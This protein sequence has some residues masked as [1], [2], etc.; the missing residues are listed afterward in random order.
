MATVKF[1]LH[2]TTNEEV[3]IYTYLSLGKNNLIET[4]TGF[5]IN[6]KNW[7]CT[8]ERKDKNDKTIKPKK[9]VGLP[10][11]NIAETKKLHNNIIDLQSYIFKNLN[12]SLSNGDMI[13]KY[14]LDNQIKECFNRKEKT[15]NTLL[16]SHIQYII[17]NA[18]TRKIQGTNRIGL[19]KA[20]VT[21]YKTF[22]K[23]IIQYQEHINKNIHFIDI[24]KPLV[25]KF[26]NWLMSKQEV[27]VIKKD[28]S[29][30]KT[31]REPY[32]VGYSGKQIS[33]LKGVCN[34]A[35]SN[36]IEVNP[37]CSQIETFKESKEDRYIQILTFDELE[38]IR[39][40]PVKDALNNVKK[41]LL[42][43]CDIGQRGED[44]V[45]LTKDNIRYIQNDLVLDI[46]QDKGKKTVTAPILQDYV[47]E[48]IENDFPYKISTQKLNIHVKKLCKL[49]GLTEV[50]KGY[51]DINERKVLGT[52][53][54]YELIA[55][56][57]FRRSFCSN[58]YK[59]VPT[60]VLMEISGHVREDTFL[61][62]IG[63]PK[64][65]DSNAKLFLQ[66]VNQHK[67]EKNTTLRAVN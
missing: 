40:T 30:K 67:K 53:P 18:H 1:R 6:P 59:T 2:K 33:N 65:Q 50:V 64:D 15:D 55:S 29:K 43:G 31:I 26:T 49:A 7:K 4:K 46:F 32:S 3:N 20:R 38:Q 60:P 57:C 21:S 66:T 23:L 47:K 54:K 14:W 28:G 42:I 17:E 5:T 13:D 52:Y 22:K 62:Y 16:V 41:W 37:Y 34:D 27:N 48:I 63:K 10:K 19:G 45:Y 8:S 58:Y 25:E 11:Q 44:L 56:H 24:N 61:L 51:K 12:I 9:P 36:L 39:Q 35:K